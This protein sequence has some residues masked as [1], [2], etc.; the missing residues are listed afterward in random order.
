LSFAACLFVK[1]AAKSSGQK[2]KA[3]PDKLNL[4]SLDGLIASAIE[5]LEIEPLNQQ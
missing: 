2:Y 4:N 5:P 1:I 3:S